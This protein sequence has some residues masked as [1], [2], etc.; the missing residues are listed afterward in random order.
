MSKSKVRAWTLH[1]SHTARKQTKCSR[2]LKYNLLWLQRTEDDE[3]EM[4][5]SEAEMWES[6]TCSDKCPCSRF[7]LISCQRLYQCTRSYRTPF[8]FTWYKA[9]GTARHHGLIYLQQKLS[10]L[11]GRCYWL[12]ECGRELHFVLSNWPSNSC[13]PGYSWASLW[14]ILKPCTAHDA[15]FILIINKHMNIL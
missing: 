13:W 2:L 8:F 6:D 3:S 15:L 4:S 11:I 7:S 12:E 14:T 5:I 9:S 10:Q 1:L